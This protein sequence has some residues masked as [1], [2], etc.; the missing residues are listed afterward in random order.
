ML[1]QNYPPPSSNNIKSV[2]NNFFVEP[3]VRLF[4]LSDSESFDYGTVGQPNPS[5]IRS[6][7]IDLSRKLSGDFYKESG[8]WNPS[9]DFFEDI[10]AIIPW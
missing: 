6:L 10:G 1:S 7:F 8:L 2:I 3:E 9:Q 4:S 5:G